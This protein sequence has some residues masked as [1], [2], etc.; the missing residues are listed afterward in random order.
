VVLA[1]SSGRKTGQSP[2]A[3]DVVLVDEFGPQVNP[4]SLARQPLALCSALA[5]RQLRDRQTRVLA[6]SPLAVDLLLADQET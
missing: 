6:Q 5:R 1:E 2:A 4:S 3:I